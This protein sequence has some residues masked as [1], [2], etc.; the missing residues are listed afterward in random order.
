MD[1]VAIDDNVLEVWQF[2]LKSINGVKTK[3]SLYSSSRQ[4]VHQNMS[5]MLS[6]RGNTTRKKDQLV[7]FF[8]KKTILAMISVL[9]KVTERKRK[10]SGS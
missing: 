4:C 5:S 10:V 3:T 2:N 6:I 9:K 1:D 8:N 7:S